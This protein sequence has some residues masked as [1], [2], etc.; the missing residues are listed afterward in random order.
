MTDASGETTLRV[1]SAPEFRNTVEGWKRL[2]GRMTRH[3]GR[4]PLRADDAAV[5]VWFGT[6]SSRLLSMQLG[7]GRI[8][9]SLEDATV[10]RPRVGKRTGGTTMIR[11]GS[12][13]K[14]VNLR[15]VV[16]RNQVKEHL[17]LK[18]RSAKSRFTFRIRDPR[19][20]LGAAKRG[21]RGEY[22]FSGA[23]GGDLRLTLPAPMAWSV[24]LPRGTAIPGDGSA[25]QRVARTRSGY[26]VRIWLDADWARGQRYP[27]VLDPTQTYS[28]SGGTLA[29]AYGPWL[30]NACDGAPCPLS[31]EPDGAVFVGRNDYVANGFLTD[32][33][34]VL[35]ADLSNVSPLTDITS[36]SLSIR[37]EDDFE[38]MGGCAY[39]AAHGV[40]APIA[41]GM[42]LPQ[43]VVQEVQ[44]RVGRGERFE[45]VDPEDT[46]D[47]DIDLAADV[48]EPLRRMLESGAGAFT[49][50]V[51]TKDNV[52]FCPQRASAR[53]KSLRSGPTLGA[54]LWLTD[55]VLEIVYQGPALPPPLPVE[56]SWGCDCRWFHGSDLSRLVADPVNTANGHAMETFTDLTTPG[57][58]IPVSWRRTY[59]G[60][61]DTDGPLGVGW[62]T[63]YQASVLEDPVSGDV[64]FRDP[65]GGRS[66]FELQPGG[67]YVGDPGVTGAL[68]AVG[69]GGWTL[70]SLQG[71][72]LTFD[73]E[74]FLLSDRDRAG[75]GVTLAYSGSGANREIETITDEV[76]RV[77]AVTYGTT[78]AENGRIVA[79]EADD[80]RDLEYGYT[81]ISG[82]PRL[83]SVTGVDGEVTAIDYDSITGRLDGITSARGSDNARNVYDPVTGR[84]V[85]QT[86]AEDNVSEFDWVPDSGA[87]PDGTG[88]QIT[89]D[90]AGNQARD[91]YYGHVLIRQVDANGSVTRYTHDADANL[92]AIQDP[93]GYVTTMTYDA[94]GNMLSRTAPAPL[95]Y[96]EEWTYDGNNNV[97]SYTD[98]RGKTTTYTY[99]GH[100]QVETITD[101]ESNTTIY[102]YTALGMVDT[103]TTAEGRATNHDY[104]A[105]GNL[106]QT[107]SPG[108]RVTSYDVDSAGRVVAVTDPR[109]NQ[110]GASAEDYTTHYTY[111]DA[112]RRLTVINPADTVTVNTY[113]D[114]G[115]L[116]DVIT[117]DN[118]SNVLVDTHFTYD[119]L[120]RMLTTTEFTRTTASNTYDSVGS[121]ISSTDAEGNTT[122]YTHDSAGRVIST[123]KPRGNEPGA[124]PGEHTWIYTYD[125]N[126]NQTSVQNPVSYAG[127]SFDALNRP[128]AV[129]TWSGST[130]TSYDGAGNVLAVTDPRG[131]VTTSTYD[132]TGRVVSHALPGED[133]TLYAYDGDGLRTSATSPSGISVTT[134]TYTGDGQLKT[135][136]DPLGNAPGGTPAN[137]TTTFGYDAA[138]NQSSVTNQL[139]R[140]TSYEYDAL[141][142]R[143]EQTDA[144]NRVT[145]WEYDA[146]NRLTAVA[147]PATGTPIPVRFSYDVHGDV[148]QRTNPAG[149]TWAYDYNQVHQLTSVT[150]P[151]ARERTFNYDADGNL[152]SWVTARGNEPG[153]TAA[154]WTVAQSFD[155]AGRVRSRTT[156]DAS[157]DAYFEYDGEGRL[158]W[159]T[160][161]MIDGTLL[162]YDEAGNLTSVDQPGS[163]DYAYTYT[164]ANRIATRG[165][166]SGGTISYTYTDDGQVDTLTANSQTT[167]FEYNANGALTTT[168]Y[169]TT[170]GMMEERNYDRSGQIE[171]IRTKVP[172]APTAINRY[173]YTRDQVGKPTRIK[174]SRGTTVYN[175]AFAYNQKDW[176]TKYC[177]GSTTCTGSAT[178]YIAYTHNP[179]GSR[180]QEDRVNVP[181]PGTTTWSY[182]DA[183]QQTKKTLG[184]VV[185]NYTYSADGQLTSN[186]RE[187]NVLGQ[188][189]ESDVNAHTTY[190]YDVLGNRRTATTGTDTTGL[191]WDINNP[192]PMLAVTTDP[193]GNPSAHRHTPT[194]E[195]LATDHPHQTYTRSYYTHD[196]QGSVVTTI[197]GS[198][199]PTRETGYEPYGSIITTTSLIA[200]A[201]PDPLGYTSA[202]TEPALGELHLRARD[203]NPTIGRFQAPDPADTPSS[204]VALPTYHYA[205][206]VP[207]VLVDRSGESSCNPVEAVENV[208]SSLFGGSGIMNLPPCD[209][210]GAKDQ[211]FNAVADDVTEQMT[212]GAIESATGG[213]A[214]GPYDT[215]Q[216]PAYWIGYGYGFGLVACLLAPGGVVDK[217]GRGGSGLAAKSGTELRKVGSVL[218]SVD[219]VM[220]NPSLLKGRHPALVEDIL[221]GTPGWQVERLGRGSQAGNGW[222]FRQYTQA[223]NPTGQQLRWHPGGGHHGPDPY[224]RVIG[225][226]GDLGGII[227]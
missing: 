185:T 193:L 160:S 116:T 211:A 85:E 128:V 119:A 180:V 32:F 174:R 136:V 30:A 156:P 152:A 194:G 56:Q 176:L 186:G 69:G 19:H 105:D 219:D 89:T 206:N 226:N 201:L 48:T 191:S 36:A 51:I 164:D 122:T 16:S 20:L 18:R 2:S 76:G 163:D 179:A 153:A 61:D 4:W 125:E 43:P 181:S 24:G 196:A 189:V 38:G 151:L 99:T 218:G 100:G 13:S 133:P 5:P 11:Y 210:P 159:A 146:L 158:V 145:T 188:L 97:T 25:H 171:M 209:R 157:F 64:V 104:D 96:E 165:Y 28:W 220:A 198:G 3:A 68:V 42:P 75:R 87:V 50:F 217:L 142:N 54:G 86:D 21:P 17:I 197:N 35:H 27:I 149:K 52:A 95:S 114:D 33:W 83:T 208:F 47:P 207:T 132:D 141:D 223:G 55:Q 184:G 101:P 138:G 108:S 94:S 34:G 139:G 199:T 8:G 127:T 45:L 7:R 183:D 131:M 63:E 92:I 124:D 227:R 129:A 37:T 81:T 39:L 170:V 202:Y 67:D 84:I 147:Q 222:V 73:A 65:T 214:N 172:G 93:R 23:L 120:N 173:D 178:T 144:L 62:T 57:P 44:S 82:T 195:A 169:P 167:T 190:T 58:G 98:R 31:S 59:N 117:T 140:T 212:D 102:T 115:N 74:G 204:Q 10:D 137:Y 110:P 29:S 49:N 103:I 1:Y 216:G 148:V 41:Q 80:G 200:G 66:R 187:W 22:K 15:Y 79:V 88:V 14:G 150:D 175:E 155:T 72:V 60:L 106:I 161:D 130:A 182:D 71:E 12:V 77:T 70:T 177:P 46:Y 123:T 143:I 6:D 9:W 205:N 118:V 192:L 224:W 154:D 111:D 213:L 215:E 107:T 112:G 90:A 53:P 221:R 109:G 78:G 203:Y 135:Q 91:V 162:T 113:D 166:P 121:L 26:R 40:G 225:P 168:T 126:G 134:W